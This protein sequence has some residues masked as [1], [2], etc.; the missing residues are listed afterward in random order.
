MSEIIR[1]SNAINFWIPPLHIAEIF[2]ELITPPPLPSN[3]GREFESWETI[4]AS[5]AS[6]SSTLLP[7]QF[8]F[9]G[10][11]RLPIWTSVTLLFS[12]GSLHVPIS[13]H[14]F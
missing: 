14:S 2:R 13:Y 3:K 6:Y 9:T 12:V 7:I 11:P 1:N 4:S 10:M 5:L 8:L